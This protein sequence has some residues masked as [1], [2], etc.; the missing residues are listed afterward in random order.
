MFGAAG[1]MLGIAIGFN[2]ITTHGA[3]TAIFVAI[4]AGLG[5]GFASI[6]TLGRLTW[7]AWVGLIFL[8]AAS[9]SSTIFQPPPL[10]LSL[11]FYL[12]MCRKVS[13][14]WFLVF[15]LTISV[16]VQ[17]RPDA[18]PQEGDWSSDYVLFNQPSFTQAMNAISIFLNAFGAVPAFFPI[19]SEMRDPKRYTRSLLFSHGVVAALYIL[20]GCVVYYYCGSFVSSPALGSAGKL[21]KKVCYGLSLPGLT[22]TTVLTIHV[23]SQPRPRHPQVLSNTVRTNKK[24][25]PKQFAAKYIFLRILGG[26]D[27]VN[28][29]TVKHWVTWLGCTFGC[30]CIAYIIAS[31]IPSFG[32]LS[33][34]IGAA[35]STILCVIPYGVMWLFDNWP[36]RKSATWIS[37]WT[38]H[39]VWSVFVSLAGVVVMIGGIWGSALDIHAAYSQPGANGP[40]TCADN[41]NS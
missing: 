10:S 24:T 28:K 22:V 34:L 37:G 3:C 33:S 6:R 8:I 30:S 38:W 23:S 31:T 41:S 7:I 35:F 19:V 2:A 17:D 39:A 15:T 36:Q 9:M 14:K 29:N 18:A 26:S 40:F 27:H 5:F 32:T 20:V 21:M 4:A 25:D 12:F 1:G 13:N 11:L 16:A